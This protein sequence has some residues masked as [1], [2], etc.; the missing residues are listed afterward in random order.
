MPNHLIDVWPKY[1][2]SS[3]NGGVHSEWASGVDQD[4]YKVKALVD[5]EG[6]VFI[7]QNGDPELKVLNPRVKLKYTYLVAWY[8]IHC[9]SLMTIV[10]ASEDFVPFLQNLECSTW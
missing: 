2:P 8:V 10:Q 9:P 3:C 7:D 1:C 6:N 5:D 4:I